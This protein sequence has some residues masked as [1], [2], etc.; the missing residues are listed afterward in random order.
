M[1]KKIAS[2]ISTVMSPLLVPTY[3]VWFILHTTVL[4]LASTSARY[5]VTG[6]VWLITCL[7]PALVIAALWKGGMISEPGLNK[8]ADRTIPYA[9]AMISYIA[10]GFYIWRAHAPGWML[11][12][13]GGG[14]LATTVSMAVNRWWKISAHMAAA[15]GLLGVAIAIAVSRFAVMNMVWW[16]VGI[17]LL[18]GS[19]GSARLILRR[20][21]LAQEL[22]GFA[23][24]FLC[25]FISMYLTIVLTTLK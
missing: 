5:S 12:F 1:N 2:I 15:G 16:I 25:V 19:V 9:I 21:T 22:A 3:G 4:S 7:F 13:I 11:A 8:R 23:N 17:A 24:G 10:A 20:H 6:V 18:C 14:L